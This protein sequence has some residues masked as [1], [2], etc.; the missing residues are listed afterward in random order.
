M[1]PTRRKQYVR[2]TTA[3]LVML[4]GSVLWCAN[5]VLARGKPGGGGGGN[6]QPISN[7]ALAYVDGSNLYVMTADGS[8]REK[9]VQTKGANNGRLHAPTWSPDGAVIAFL[10]E[11]DGGL[12]LYVVAADGSNLAWLHHFNGDLDNPL[13]EP[14]FGLNWVSDGSGILYTGRDLPD[15]FVFEFETGSIYGL[16]L[17]EYPEVVRG[18]SL[19]PDLDAAPGHR[20]FI[21]YSAIPPTAELNL[22]NLEIHIAEVATVADGTLAVVPGTTT[23]LE[24]PWEQNLPAWS[25]DGQA[26]TFYH[27]A[28]YAGGDQLL[29]VIVDVVNLDF[30]T[31]ELVADFSGIW[32]PTWS[33]DGQWIALCNRDQVD[34]SDDV[35]RLHPD[36]TGLTNITATGNRI[37]AYPHW[38]PAWVNDIDP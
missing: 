9:L 3:A 28:F 1:S 32:K 21:A 11:A 17:G 8:T 6:T 7:P 10:Q 19:G 12:D 18:V 30:G 38:N 22:E 15:G 16:G 13:P 35:L 34:D 27:N 26:L 31:P 33:P 14:A 37:E 23:W 20:G 24:M 4:G 2:F 36:G 5:Q 29:G 25:P